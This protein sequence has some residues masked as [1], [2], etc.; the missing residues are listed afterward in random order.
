LRWWLGYVLGMVNMEDGVVH[1]R[2]RTRDGRKLYVERRGSGGPTVVFEAGMGGS[3]S[4]WGAVVPRVAEQ[5][6]TVVYDRSGLGRSPADTEPRTLD[7]LVDDL[8]DVLDHLDRFGTATPRPFVLVGHSWGGPI[9]RSA[10][11]HAPER[12]GGLV[13]VDQTDE[14]CDLFFG[15]GAALQSRVFGPLVPL[16]GRLGLIG[17]AV[18]Q[19]AARLPEPAAS[20][21]KAEDATPTALR[22]HQAEMSGSLDD[23]RGLR[24]DPAALPEVPVTLVSGTKS[25]PL[26][27]RRRTALVAAHRARAEAL[28]QGRHVTADRS[29]HMVPFTE[30]DVVA[31][32]VLRIVDLVRAK[33]PS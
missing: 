12:V 23:L 7:R 30:P 11:T 29:A 18:K 1:D 4:A 22:T 25:S 28:P 13:L 8:G 14:G 10:A 19:L 17:L 3:R 16:M 2:A 9:V 32:E 15:R 20:D 21:M 26:G 6:T 5:T 24:D 27:R 33:A 31:D